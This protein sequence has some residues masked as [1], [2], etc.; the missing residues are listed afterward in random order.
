MSTT[1]QENYEENYVDIDGEMYEEN[2]EE[3]YEFQP[4]SFLHPKQFYW[5]P[6]ASTGL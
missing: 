1:Y 6:N 3:E 5:D 4:P 2:D